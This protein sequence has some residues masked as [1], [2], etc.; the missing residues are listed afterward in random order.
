[1]ARVCLLVLGMHRSG[2]SAITRVLSLMG[3]T[4]PGRLMPPVP[5]NNETGFWE[6]KPLAA[7][8]DALLKEVGSAWDD[9]RPVRFD[10]LADG[11]RAAFKAELRSV[12]EEEFDDASLFV[13]KDPRIC[14]LLPIYLE[15]F[16]EMGITPRFVLPL[17][18]PA[19]V[20]KSLARRDDMS[21]G[22]AS[23]LWL[24]HV[25]D[26]ESGTR[27]H[28]RVLVSYD[29]LLDDW[30]SSVDAIG[31][32]LGISWPRRKED[33]ADEVGAFLRRDLRHHS[34]DTDLLADSEYPEWIVQASA[35]LGRLKD[36]PEDL[37]QMQVLDRVARE[38]QDSAP[39]LS[40]AM[41]SELR[42]RSQRFAQR[43]A[44]IAGTKLE[45][46]LHDL[47]DE[48][49]ELK[50]AIVEAELIHLRELETVAASFSAA[51][52]ELER[53][54]RVLHDTVR[55][56]DATIATLNVTV[57]NQREVDKA[58][59]REIKNL[60]TRIAE[61]SAHRTGLEGQLA[62][63][64]LVIQTLEQRSDARLRLQLE[65]EKELHE[66][67]L[68]AELQSAEAARL[69]RALEVESAERTRLSGLVDACAAEIE[70]LSQMV[71]VETD[72]RK[73]LAAQ[74]EQE[75]ASNRSL[76][77]AN[78]HLSSSLEM[79]Y[80]S[81]SWT[82][83]RPVRAVTTGVRRARDLPSNIIRRLVSRGAAAGSPVP[84]P[85]PA[86]IDEPAPS[87]EQTAQPPATAPTVDATR[88]GG[89]TATFADSRQTG[90]IPE[91]PVFVPR[92]EAAPL[93]QKPVRAVAF[94]LPQFHPIPENDEWW[95]EGFTEWTN[96]RPAE[97]TFVGHHQPRVP[98]ELG[99]YDLRDTSVQRR[100]IELAKLYGLEGFCFYFYWFGGKRLLETPVENWLNDPTLDFPFCLCW[101]NENWS[102]RWDGLDQE[103]LIGQH[104]SPED[105]LAF[106]A[107]ASRYLRDP[108]YIRING[109]PVLII[110][111][112][113][114]LPSMNETAER[115]RGWCRENGVGEIYLAYVQSFENNDPR[116][117]GLD[118]AIEF[119]PNNSGPP[120]VTDLVVPV[121]EP[122]ASTVY[123]WSILA[124]RS[125]NYQPRSY[126]VFRSMCPGWDNTARRKRG[127][128]VFVNNTAARYRRWFENAIDDTVANIADPSE[129]L[130]FV[131]A[132][133]EW[134]E[135]AYLEP[136][137]ANGYAYLQATRDALESR[138]G[139]SSRRPVLVVTH[140]CH[141]HGAQFLTL[142]MAR[143]LKRMGHPVSI[144]ALG[145]G[146]L[147]G[148]F[149]QI[150]PMLTMGAAD[151]D[152][153]RL[154]LSGLRRSGYE[155]AIT[156]TVVSGKVVP[157]L[158]S[159]GFRIVS[160]VHEMA[161]VIRDMKL[162]E[163]ASAIAQHADAVVFPAALVRDQFRGLVPIDEAKTL[164][165]PQGV[166]R[167]NPYK[168][169]VDEAREIVWERH[170]L[171]RGT[172]IVLSVAFVDFRK[173]PDL[174]VEMA[175][176]VLDIR[177]DAAFVWI[178][179]VDPPMEREVAARVAQLGVGDRV[180][181]AGFNRD[182]MEYY[183]AASVYALT[184]REDPFP[185][186][187]LESAEVGVP[188][189]AFEGASGAADF[190]VAQ[191]GLLAA[192][193]EPGDFAR[194]V[195]QLLDQPAGGPKPPV[196]S[197]R[198]YVLDIL[199][200]FDRAPR[201]SVIV[202][203]YNYAHHIE[204]RLRSILD[205]THPIY[206]V[207]VLD[208]ASTDSS[209]DVIAGIVDGETDI[210]VTV[211]ANDA[212][213]GSVFRQWKRGI[214][215]CRGDL[216]W[217]AEADDFAETDF[218]AELA[219]GFADPATVL[220]F[221]QSR[222]V[223]E[224]G[225]VLAEDYLGYTSDIGDRWRH[226]FVCDGR[227]EVAEAMSIKN[228]IP[229]VSAVLFRRSALEKALGQ[230]GDRLFDLRIAGDWLVYVHV[231]MQGQLYFR[232]RSLNSHRRHSQS[233]T[234]A[235]DTVKHYNEVKTLQEVS[236][237][238]AEPSSEARRKADD[239]MVRLRK[240]FGFEDARPEHEKPTETVISTS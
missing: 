6:S 128:T 94:Y 212:N 155:Q 111:R 139:A 22:F 79:I 167:K 144:L 169:R 227:T 200:A 14:R 211:V 181:F 101:A 9:W 178:G 165:R 105:D 39:G 233:V 196:G 129:R 116:D 193:F 238:L 117:Y 204:Q 205:Q 107:E 213:S 210:D 87:V 20:A 163:P 41:F 54:V 71:R 225:N 74:L 231:L 72:E 176:A 209:L 56:R 162:E 157:L 137:T 92:I 96:V 29:A 15:L 59:A 173:G 83:T 17:R 183:A 174:F 191:G 115:W 199:H 124:E 13:L 126:M 168:R 224:N 3:A 40:N 25:L 62:E 170:G 133:N 120:N 86:V 221:S 109:K 38:F 4:L 50:P 118:A 58:A 48:F 134:A 47:R 119:P 194:K 195:V 49:N 136:D 70:Q 75:Q 203:N 161:G 113:S 21:L 228:T 182:P 66:A 160:L 217:I 98:G 122:F 89:S 46:D 110:Y 43:A 239:Y 201:I 5:D 33:A 82:I 78:A 148:D 28:K 30:K 44:S 237:G 166:L 23:L 69:T 63:S 145:E 177:P 84:V 12:I 18:N 45:S 192:A 108:R 67:A 2:T 99:Y 234:N 52:A 32:A 103:L 186:V 185:N 16:D 218:L 112:P 140:D 125:E 91:S 152:D 121:Q 57:A 80:K 158:K 65:I 135:G 123:D 147:Q 95:G 61:E 159:E 26:A 35:A 100:Q 31:D 10:R 130:V 141:P 180:I 114:L 172:P 81:R 230:I 36:A 127:G 219:A 232:S 198:Q 138:S 207:I 55:E 202:P 222:Q 146:P 37:E 215:M 97:P 156:S 60:E 153:V 106:I 154:F 184:S 73:R 206:E 149:A 104:H 85:P 187:V 53:Q 102:R 90:L 197:L 88:F 27:G 151:A 19:A 220:A 236:R 226:D 132:W 190:I 131:N 77:D 143:L 68:A 76:T 223:D 229:N 189:V 1:M 150:G 64:A 7:V 11:K 142:E 179:H 93:F 171:A 164:A 175:R 240:H 235:G 214:A 188:V 34:G 208:D 51:Q 216:V 24:R 8:H 42:A